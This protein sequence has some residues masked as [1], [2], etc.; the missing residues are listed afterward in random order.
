MDKKIET[1][2]AVIMAVVVGLVCG[3]AGLVIGSVLNKPESIKLSEGNFDALSLK[4]VTSVSAQITG[5]VT[6]TSADEITVEREG[7]RL[8]LDIPEAAN[9]ISLTIV[10]PFTEEDQKV[11]DAYQEQLKA[12][13]EEI[14]KMNIDPAAMDPM[15]DMPVYPQAPFSVA[16]MDPAMMDPAAGETAAQQ[17]K[18]EQKAVKPDE[19]KAG[20]SIS[21]T[22][23]L[24][25][26]ADPMAVA[27]EESGTNQLHVISI[28]AVRSITE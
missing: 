23:G 10:S 21:A 4:P 8:T 12:Y 15:I 11:W 17:T 19:L 14:A 16:G 18:S 24:G 25:A 1:K 5:V 20:D 3:A 13:E 6:S 26:Y 22:L 28:S 7:E 27:G 2:L 9:M